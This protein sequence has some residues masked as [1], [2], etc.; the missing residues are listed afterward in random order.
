MRLFRGRANEKISEF[1]FLRKKAGQLLFISYDSGSG[2]LP[3]EN[4]RDIERLA[5]TLLGRFAVPIF[6]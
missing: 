6:R 3:L 1:R 5:K 4:D 2:E